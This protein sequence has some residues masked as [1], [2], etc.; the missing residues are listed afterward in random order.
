MYIRTFLVASFLIG[1]MHIAPAQS[2][3]IS[4]YH[5]IAINF[6]FDSSAVPDKQLKGYRLFASGKLIC[7]KA[8]TAEVKPLECTVKLVDGTYPFTLA[9]AFQ[10]GTA[11][12]Q[13]PPFK[14]TLNDATAL[15]R[16]DTIING[17][18]LFKK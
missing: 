6:A 2:F 12:A 16:I 7:E 14:F 9:V 8:A 11:T 17:F 3:A 15:P 5:R 10:D 1:V 18:L 4:A 13:S